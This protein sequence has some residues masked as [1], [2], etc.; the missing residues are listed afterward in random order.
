MATQWISLSKI[1][2]PLVRRLRQ[3]MLTWTSAG[4]ADGEEPQFINGDLF[5]VKD[6]PAKKKMRQLEAFLEARAHQPPILYYE[7]LM[8][9]WTAGPT[10]QIYHTL[11]NRNANLRFARSDSLIL[12][13]IEPSCWSDFTEELLHIQGERA[14][15]AVEAEFEVLIAHVIHCAA[16]WEKLLSAHGIDRAIIISSRSV[17]VGWNDEDVI[18]GCKG[19][20]SWYERY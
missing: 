5:L 20:P 9:P 12:L 14:W 3:D 15:G 1:A 13:L 16:S 17:D 11:R 18:N 19:L 2:G 6:E 7:K 8:D 10:F 4:P